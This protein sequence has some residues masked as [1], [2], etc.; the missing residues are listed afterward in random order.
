MRPATEHFKPG[1]GCLFAVEFEDLA[2]TKAFY[3]NLNVHKGPHLGA[4]FTLAFAYTMCAYKSKLDWA[5]RYG[6]RPTQ[7]RIS[8]GLED[9]ATLLQDFKVAVAAASRVN[10]KVGP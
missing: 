7:L 10:G 4:P 6:L 9:T 1:F 5:S 8:A 3:D 2:A